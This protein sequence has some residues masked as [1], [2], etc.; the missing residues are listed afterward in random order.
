MRL[1]GTIDEEKSETYFG[2]K[3]LDE[4]NI[5][6]SVYNACRA[7]KAV[8]E[9]VISKKKKSLFFFSCSNE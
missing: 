7:G 2:P 8:N 9:K 3:D 5:F 1:N 4:K 6:F